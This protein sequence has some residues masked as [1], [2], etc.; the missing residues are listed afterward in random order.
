MNVSEVI[1]PE[2]LQRTLQQASANQQ[3]PGPEDGIVVVNVKNVQVEPVDSNSFAIRFCNMHRK[4]DVLAG[5]LPAQIQ[6][7]VVNGLNWKGPVNEYVNAQLTLSMNGHSQIVA[8]T[9]L[10]EATNLVNA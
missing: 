1:Q 9:Y 7:P 2:V 4:V 5:A 8:A 3:R 10:P 6:A